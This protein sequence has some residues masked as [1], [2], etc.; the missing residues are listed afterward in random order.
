[1]CSVFPFSFF[2][3]SF[4]FLFFFFGSKF[5]HSRSK[6]C[7]TLSTRRFPYVNS[8]T[9]VGR[10]FYQE[11][12]WERIRTLQLGDQ[13]PVDRG[14][15]ANLLRA[16][17]RELLKYEMSLNLPFYKIIIGSLEGF[18]PSLGYEPILTQR[19]P[20][21]KRSQRKHHPT[22]PTQRERMVQ[23]QRKNQN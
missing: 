12:V 13:N 22:P 11:K 5:Y 15:Q 10:F 9:K 6:S 2:P 23:W 1:M 19:P 7:F 14:E 8:T 4:F 3:S 21:K 16:A 18:L 20:R 17:H